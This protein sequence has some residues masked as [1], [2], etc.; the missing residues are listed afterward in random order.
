MAHAYIDFQESGESAGVHLTA[1]ALTEDGAAS[2]DAP[3]ELD[4]PS[5]AEETGH[6]AADARGRSEC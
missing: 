5:D 1:L 6:A 3:M 4:E 2:A